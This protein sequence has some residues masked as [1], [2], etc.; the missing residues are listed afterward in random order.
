[1]LSI[2]W[3]QVSSVSQTSRIPTP[4]H[5]QS[6]IGQQN[7]IAHQKR[8][9]SHS[10]YLLSQ[11]Q[12]A[13]CTSSWGT[14]QL[15]L[16]CKNLLDHSA[17]RISSPRQ[18]L[19]PSGNSCSS[20]EVA[21]EVS[22][23]RF[24]GICRCTCKKHMAWCQA[25]FLVHLRMGI[26]DNKIP[27]PCSVITMAAYPEHNFFSFFGLC[28]KFG[29]YPAPKRPNL[30]IKHE[31]QV[32]HEG[33]KH[34]CAMLQVAKYTHSGNDAVQCG[35]M[36]KTGIWLILHNFL[37]YSDDSSSSNETHLGHAV[38]FHDRIQHVQ[39]HSCFTML[40]VI[41]AFQQD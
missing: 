22:L 14:R 23:Q 9:T 41:V 20:P 40:F 15:L 17:L 11:N 28:H 7:W 34:G 24:Q 19:L 3:P 21:A 18:K 39:R 33:M 13:W 30:E 26:I 36:R 12:A 4:Y 25:N 16:C 27:N 35:R 8:S 32:S 38:F 10:R 5:Q 2:A 29:N 1:M 6:D 37:W 31:E